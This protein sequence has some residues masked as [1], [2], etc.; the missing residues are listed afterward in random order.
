MNLARQQEG[1][2]FLL[3]AAREAWSCLELVGVGWELVGSVAPSWVDL[4]YVIGASR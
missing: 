4:S 2:L 1:K 3:L